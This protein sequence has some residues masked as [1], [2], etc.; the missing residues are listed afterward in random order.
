MAEAEIEEKQQATITKPNVQQIKQNLIKECNLM[1]NQIKLSKVDVLET[2]CNEN[3]FSLVVRCIT[4]QSKYKWSKKID[5]LQC[6][7]NELGYCV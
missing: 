1:L 6:Q 2:P 7:L 4:Y 3:V 5:T